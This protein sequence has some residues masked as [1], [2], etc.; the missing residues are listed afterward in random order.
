MNTMQMNPCIYELYT[1]ISEAVTILIMTQCGAT[2]T[3]H[4]PLVGARAYTG[5]EANYYQGV[6][7]IYFDNVNCRGS[8]EFLSNCSAEPVGE[9]DCYHSEDAGV[10]CEGNKCG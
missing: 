6:G 2:F 9:H 5:L 3:V 7:P 1:Y 8:E 4:F 10:L